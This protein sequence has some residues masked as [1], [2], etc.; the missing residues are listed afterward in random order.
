[1]NIKKSISVFAYQAFLKHGGLYGYRNMEYLGSHTKVFISCT[2]HGDFL[3]TPCNHL[4]GSGCPKCATERQAKD[5]LKSTHEFIE[6]S[7]KV[8]KGTYRY[9]ETDYK[10][11]FVKVNIL[12]RIHGSFKQT[13]ANHLLGSGCPKCS[14][15]GYQRGLP[16]HLYL[17]LCDDITKIGITNLSPEQRR[18]D[19]SRS[20]GSSF[21]VVDSWY[22]EDGAFPDD[23]ETTILRELRKEYSSPSTKFDGSSE[24][25]L[26]VDYNKLVSRISDC[27]AAH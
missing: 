8:H 14:V 23:L 16:G 20:Y 17:M 15:T 21:S 27:I 3:Q 25:F 13:P 18:R 4:R 1:V 12:C 5:I 2:I 24:C 22:F 9:S 10:G 19:I 6:D 11:C 26:D 7:K